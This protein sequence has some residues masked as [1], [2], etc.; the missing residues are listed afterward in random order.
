MDL[1]RYCTMDLLYEPS[2]NSAVEMVKQ[3]GPTVQQLKAV[4]EFGRVTSSGIERILFV[5]AGAG[6]A[7][8]RSLK[9]YTDEVGRN[10]RYA[11]YASATF[12]NLMRANPW[13]AND[14]NT[15]VL[16]SSKSGR[17][18]ETVAAA[19]FLKGKPCKTV[20]FTK[21]EDAVLATFGHRGF[22][23]GKTTQAF[24]A[25]HML[26]ASFL[27]GVLEARENWKLLPALLSSL[28]ALPAALFHAA[29]KGV[30]PG[31]TFAA[32]FA[33]DNPLYF[34]ASGSAGIVPHAYGLCVLQERFGFYIHV[35]DGADFF[36]SFV[37]SV[38][39][40]KPGHYILIIPDDPSRPEM[41]D[42]KNFFE[43]QFKEGGVSLQVIDTKG[44][45]MSGIDPQIERLVGPMLSEAFLKPWAPALAKATGRSMDDS[46][47]HMGKFAYYNCHRA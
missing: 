23:T 1:T 45:D 41:L 14:A 47:L 34:I 3:L 28:D 43:T 4:A 11:E 44:F 18:P 6:L 12:V 19:A 46:L 20:V 8:G 39:P 25:T 32:G 13:M 33:E 30:L 5:S 42:V 7:I 21:S 38:R 37:E 17:T 16:L 36:H 27:G 24:H 29:E 2:S 9:R 15:V 40:G 35:V 22:F 26:M 10:L 31:K